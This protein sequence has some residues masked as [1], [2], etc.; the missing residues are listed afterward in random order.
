MR[1]LVTSMMCW[2][3]TFYFEVKILKNEFPAA[4][5]LSIT[6]CCRLIL[7]SHEFPTFGFTSV[8]LPDGQLR[9]VQRLQRLLRPPFPLSDKE[10]I[11]NNRKVAGAGVTEG[12]GK[13]ACAGEAKVT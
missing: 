11:R 7:S 6:L 8:F 4:Q 1:S 13:I 5:I 3:G 10:S 9:G 12:F 2:V